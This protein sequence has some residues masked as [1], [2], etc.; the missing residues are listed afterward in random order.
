MIRQQIER[1]IGGQQNIQRI[2]DAAEMQ[3]NPIE[4]FLNAVHR[5][6][7]RSYQIEYD[8]HDVNSYL[9]NGSA[10]EERAMCIDKLA[11]EYRRLNRQYQNAIDVQVRHNGDGMAPEAPTFDIFVK[12]IVHGEDGTGNC[13]QDATLRL[14]LLY[15]QIVRNLSTENNLFDY[16]A[17]KESGFQING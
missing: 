6:L 2:E 11:N 7:Y 10:V 8:F 9:A 14:Q 5:T 13:L 15:N 17:A 3:R 1:R 12:K 16:S 4:D